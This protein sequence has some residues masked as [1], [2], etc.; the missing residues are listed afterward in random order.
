MN[1]GSNK[2]LRFVTQKKTTKTEGQGGFPE[3]VL[4]KLRREERAAL[5][6]VG[7]VVIAGKWN[8]R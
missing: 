3:E 4:V 7:S 8:P 1:G 2:L 5:N 6:S